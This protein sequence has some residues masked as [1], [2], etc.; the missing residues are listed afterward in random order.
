MASDPIQLLAND[1]A[2]EDLQDWESDSY[3]A[4]GITDR[5]ARYARTRANQCAAIAEAVGV[6][7]G[8]H[9]IYRFAFALSERYKV[10]ARQEVGSVI[11]RRNQR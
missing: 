11:K 9:A 8:G 6:M 2:D 5:V 7:D 3:P 10:Y 1:L 4:D